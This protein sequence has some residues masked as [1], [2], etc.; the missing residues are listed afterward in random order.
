MA[1][2]DDSLEEAWRAEVR[3]RIEQIDSAAVS[4]IPWDEARRRL[5][6]SKLATLRS[7]ID[8]GGASGIAE[9]DVFARLRRRSTF[10]DAPD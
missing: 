3:R 6:E 1:R 7:A 9:G 5:Y 10:P 4:L 8:D 2:D